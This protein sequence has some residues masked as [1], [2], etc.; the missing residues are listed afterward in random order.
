ML[1]DYRTQVSNCNYCTNSETEKAK[2]VSF[3]SL[4]APVVSNRLTGGVARNRHIQLQERAYR[5]MTTETYIEPAFLLPDLIEIQRS[6]SA[7]FWKIEELNSFSPITD[8]TGVRVALW[9]KIS[10]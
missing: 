5:R 3:Q 6:A 7:G 10:N 4:S 8:Y 2:K 1:Q 9:V